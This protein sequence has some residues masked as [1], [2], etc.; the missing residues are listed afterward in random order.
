MAKKVK[1]KRSKLKKKAQSVAIKKA[2][3]IKKAQG[4]LSFKKTKGNK[5]IKVNAKTGKIKVGK[6]LKKG[7]YPI[8][9]KITAS[10]NAQYKKG[11]KTVKVTIKVN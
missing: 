3:T 9:I 8:K 5:K 1:I 11:S 7:T 6:G 2:V 4:T 10:G